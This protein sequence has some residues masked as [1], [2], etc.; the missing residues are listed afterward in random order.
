MDKR[1]KKKVLQLIPYGAYVVGT[2]ME[3]GS[4]H[5]MFGTWLTQT[6]FKPTLVAFALSEDSRTLA[7]VRR[8][9]SFAVSFLAPG[10]EDLAQHVLDEAF[11]KVKTERTASGLATVTGAAAWME[12]KSLD[13]LERGDHRVVLAEV[14]DAAA[15]SAELLLLD[16]LGWHYGG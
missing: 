7:N 9:Q 10:M 5:L 16:A 13:V 4:D 3:D 12:C 15:V 14:V 6:S 2:K 11:D 1:A 8:D